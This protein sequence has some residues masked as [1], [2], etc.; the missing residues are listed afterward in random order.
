VKAWTLNP[1]TFSFSHSYFF[2]VF[3]FLTALQFQLALVFIFKPVVFI[4]FAP[5]L[6]ARKRARVKTTTGG[7]GSTKGQPY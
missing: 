7:G 5:A 3:S 4:I 6:T 2:V 1:S